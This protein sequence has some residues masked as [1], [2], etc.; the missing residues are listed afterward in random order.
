MTGRPRAPGPAALLAGFLVASPLAAQGG[1]EAADPMVTDRPDFTESTVAVERLQ[2]EAG[3]TLDRTAGAEAHT[4]GEALL[5]LPAAPG[6]EVRLGLS[7]Y[8][9]ADAAAGADG[10]TD[11]S[12][13]LKVRAGEGGPS[14]AL[15]SVAFLAGTT[16]PLGDASP[17][18]LQPFTKLAFG[19]ELGPGLGLGA[20]VGAAYLD[21]GTKRYEE[22]SGSLALG[23]DAGGGVGLYLET[24]GFRPVGRPSTAFVD[25]GFTLKLTPDAQVDARVGTGVDGPAQDLVLGLGLSLRR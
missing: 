4:L 16:V 2:L 23:V 6:V 25:G 12:V 10:F 14:P 17:A 11:S 9:W 15:P 7:S 18:G 5:R 3:Y 19:W 20:N 13:G 24:Y 21:D 22:Y 8:R 1:G